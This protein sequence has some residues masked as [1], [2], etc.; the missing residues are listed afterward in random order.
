MRREQKRQQEEEQG[1]KMQEAL[2]EEEIQDV[3]MEDILVEEDT[4]RKRIN[5]L[6]QITRAALFEEKTICKAYFVGKLSNISDKEVEVILKIIKFVKPYMASRATYHI[7]SHQ[8]P[9]LLMIN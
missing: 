6:K 4:S 9:F 8:I 1:I 5:Q 7:F 3:D 2:V